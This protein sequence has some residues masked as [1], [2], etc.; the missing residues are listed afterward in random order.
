MHVPSLL[1]FQQKRQDKF[2]HIIAVFLWYLLLWPTKTGF[3]D[4]TPEIE[5]NRY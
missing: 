2:R 5:Q 1:R 4:V 3:M